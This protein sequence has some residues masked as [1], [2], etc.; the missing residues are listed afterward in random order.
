MFFA[1]YEKKSLCNANKYKKIPPLDLLQKTKKTIKFPTKLG[2]EKENCR[3]M[4]VCVQFST[5]CFSP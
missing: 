3:I 1:C 5:Q 4:S 2:K